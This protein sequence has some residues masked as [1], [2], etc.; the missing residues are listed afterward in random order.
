MRI[1][2]RTTIILDD[3][4]FQQVR[5]KAA[6]T[7]QTLSDIINNALRQ[8]LHV[9]ATPPPAPFRMVIFGGGGKEQHE[10]SDFARI[11]EEDDQALAGR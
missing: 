5:Q 11:L 9:P 3:Q 8:A 1:F 10:P 2:M 7:G 6:Q 4:L